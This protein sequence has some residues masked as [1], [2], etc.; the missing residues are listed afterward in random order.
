MAGRLKVGSQQ[1]APCQIHRGIEK[2]GGSS[3]KTLCRLSTR[4]MCNAAGCPR[5]VCAMCAANAHRDPELEMRKSIRSNAGRS[6]GHSLNLFALNYFPR[7]GGRRIIG[8]TGKTL[9]H[10]S[11]FNF[12]INWQH[13]CSSF[14]GPPAL[15]LMCVCPKASTRTPCSLARSPCA[16]N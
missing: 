5:V 2:R 4:R 11:Q 12:L 3:K 9:K 13:Q 14:A 7:S 15:A 1:S 8:Q 10:F 6:N 16:G